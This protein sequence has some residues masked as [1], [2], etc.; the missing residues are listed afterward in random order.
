MYHRGRSGRNGLVTY[1]PNNQYVIPVN[2]SIQSAVNYAVAGHTIHVAP[3]TY[4][5]NFNVTLKVN[6]IG[7]GS[8]SD[9]ASNTVLT[10]T[11]AGAGDSK[12]GVVQLN[13]SG[14]IGDPVLIKDIRI[15]PVG[16]AGISVGKFTQSTGVNV[17]HVSLDN[18]HVY[19]TYQPS[20][21]SEQERGLYVDLTSLLSNLTITNSAFN[22]LVYG[23][24]L[25]K[26]VSADAST[27]TNVSVSNTEFKDNTS[28]GLYAEKLNNATFDGC[29]VT[30]NGDAAWGN[31]CVF[32]KPFLAGFDINLKS[33]SYQNIS[34]RNSVFT[35]NGTG[36]AKEGAALVIKARNDAPA[37]ASFPASLANVLVENCIISGNER[38]IRLGEPDKSNAGPTNV[39]IRNNAINA[40]LKTYSGTDGTAYGNIINLTAATTTATCNWYGSNVAAN[41]ALGIFGPVV[42]VPFLEDGNDGN[43]SIGFQPTAVCGVTPPVCLFRVVCFQQGLT[44]GGAPVPNN[45][46]ILSSAEVAQ[47]SDTPPINF[48][49]LGF[50][51]YITLRSNCPVKNG[52]GNDIK[53]WETTYGANPINAFSERARVYASQD[54]I[55]FLLLGIATYDGSFDLNTAGLAWASYFR[56]QDITTDKPTNPAL[57]DGY[58]VDGIEVL[59]GYADNTTPTPIMQGGASSVCGGMQGK[60]KNFSTISPIRS[61]PSKA[62]GLPQNNN[63]FN[64]YSLGFGGDICLKFDF[65]VF[66]GPGGELKVIET[67]FGNSTC[68][69]YKERAEIAVSFDNVSWNVLGVY[70]QD[71]AGS[72]DITPANSGIQ[73]VRVRDVSLRSDFSSNAADGYDVDAVVAM[74][75]FSSTPPCPSVTN[76]RIATSQPEL[77][78]Q[79]N[80][81]DEIDGLQI[82]G[83]PVSDQLKIR[84]TQVAEQSNISIYNYLG[85]QVLNEDHSGNLWELKELTLPVSQLAPGAY[86]LT[87]KSRGSKET[88]PFVKL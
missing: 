63:T 84:F 77:F 39:V 48:Y 80:V 46:S 85:Q 64:F 67:T 1:V 51:G 37:Y 58:D 88:I 18:V 23:W 72:I 22:G 30:N 40:N 10:Q 34:I 33:G 2:P 17:S 83:N 71:F 8:G 61:Q 52:Q 25:Q 62:T 13:A 7:S 81:P 5:Q 11:A 66:D 57:A 45:R 44:H 35:G 9:P 50:G 20:A 43:V 86:L 82:I 87:V 14:S 76:G 68:N 21:C 49:S 70:C 74:S 26:A 19:G 47:K 59:N 60:T 36:E 38:G 29:T 69:S 54:G 15:Q 79:N 24:Y 53:V 3:G 73:Y 42:Y 41:V 16:M 32:F 12:I 55:H 31:T 4:S 75:S 65:A 56:I 78:D 28:K 6:I 27:V